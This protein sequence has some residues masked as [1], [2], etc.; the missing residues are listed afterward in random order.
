LGVISHGRLLSLQ[1]DLDVF[2]VLSL[3]RAER[4]Y[5]EGQAGKYLNAPLGMYR[6]LPPIEPSV[7][8]DFVAFEEHIT[9]MKKNEPGDGKVPQQWYDAPVHIYMNPYTVF[10]ANDTIP[11][12]PETKA[13]DFEM[14]VAAI[15]LKRGSDVAPEEASSYIA[16]YCILNDWSARDIQGQEMRV[17]LGPSKGKDFATTL[18]PW[19][20]T[21]DELEQYRVG[22]RYDLE[23]TVSIN[24]VKF[25]QDSLKNMAWSFEDLIVHTSRASVI[26]K[27]DVLASGTCSGGSL[28]EAWANNGR[29]E[30]RPLQVGDVVE[31][32]VTGLGTISNTIGETRSP[33]HKIPK[34]RTAEH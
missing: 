8:R 21:P 14:E 19:I 32:T 29:Q 1:T 30:P 20:T 33:N 10:G 25:G 12:P 22:D 3:P 23:M 5:L 26:G 31:M 18:G 13:M 15:V 9:A 17:G 7:M 16:G 27:G 4:D 11:M 34:A 6:L 24:G 28:A 2:G